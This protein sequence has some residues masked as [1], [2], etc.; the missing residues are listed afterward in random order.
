MGDGGTVTVIRPVKAGDEEE[1]MPRESTR[2]EELI[3]REV[4]TEDNQRV[5]KIEGVVFDRVDRAVHVVILVG[6]LPH[7]KHRHKKR[8]WRSR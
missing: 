2:G 3:G 4:I 7:L 6:D 8:R 1:D 5:G